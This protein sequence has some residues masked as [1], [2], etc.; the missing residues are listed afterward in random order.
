MA[1]HDASSQS[2]DRFCRQYLQLERSLDFPDATILREE[3]V[4]SVLFQRVF[5]DGALRHPPPPRYQLKALKTL[6][7]K[8]EDSIEDWEQHVRI[9]WL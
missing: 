1:A 7:S 4:Q 5:A 2:I 9:Q 3:K 8:I 6:T